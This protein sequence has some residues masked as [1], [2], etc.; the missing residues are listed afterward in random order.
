MKFCGKDD[1]VTTFSSAANREFA[2]QSWAG[3]WSSSAEYI[4]VITS[5][6]QK[7]APVVVLNRGRASR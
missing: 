3:R 5:D 1:A 7:L 2:C 6:V 4:P